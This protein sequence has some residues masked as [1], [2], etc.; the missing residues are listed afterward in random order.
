[1]KAIPLILIPLVIVF[2]ALVLW[3]VSQAKPHASEA[4][5]VPSE[6]GPWTSLGF[7]STGMRTGHVFKRIDP[8]TGAIIYVMVGAEFGGLYVLPAPVKQEGK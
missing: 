8:D 5:I 6:L 4:K 3:A 7:V 2:L 1:M